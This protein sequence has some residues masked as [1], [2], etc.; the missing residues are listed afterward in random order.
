MRKIRLSIGHSLNKVLSNVS[1]MVS[2]AASLID[3]HHPQ[4]C[5]RLMDLLLSKLLSSVPELNKL[6]R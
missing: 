2:K 5:S 6:P 1:V 4:E 3:V